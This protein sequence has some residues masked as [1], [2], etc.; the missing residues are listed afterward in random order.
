MSLPDKIDREGL[1]DLPQIEIPPGSGNFVPNVFASK[2]NAFR[3]AFAQSITMSLDTAFTAFDLVNGGDVA[4]ARF[5]KSNPAEAE[6][7][8]TARQMLDGAVNVSIPS[9]SKS[10]ARAST[11]PSAATRA[12]TSSM[13]ATATTN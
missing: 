1:Y 10:L 8:F 13:R 3:T 12:P 2:I 11:T 7:S 9:T 5:E 6:P 4:T